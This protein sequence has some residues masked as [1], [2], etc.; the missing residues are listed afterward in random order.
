M[1]LHE[2]PGIGRPRRPWGTTRAAFFIRVV[3]E[4]LGSRRPVEV[5][6][7]GAGDACLARRLLGHWPH[8]GS[9]TGAERR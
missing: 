6:D 1:D 4:H 7:I 8:Y 5:L 3:L 2:S 9:L